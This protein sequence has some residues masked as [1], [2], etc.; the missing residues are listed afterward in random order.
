MTNLLAILFFPALIGWG[1]TF[2][3]MRSQLDQR[4]GG[5]ERLEREARDLRRELQVLRSRVKR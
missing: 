3:I 1:I 2:W 5:I 4:E